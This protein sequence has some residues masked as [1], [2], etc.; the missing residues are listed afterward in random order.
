MYA[1]FLKEKIVQYERNKLKKGMRNLL[2]LWKNYVKRRLIHGKF[3]D[4]INLS[5]CNVD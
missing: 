4:I 3:Y 1:F 5:F 2:L